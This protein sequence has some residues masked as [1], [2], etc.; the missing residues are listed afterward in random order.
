M[1]DAI[2]EHGSAEDGTDENG[3]LVITIK[4]DGEHTVDSDLLDRVLQ[5]TMMELEVDTAW[6]VGPPTTISPSQAPE[7]SPAPEDAPA[8]EPA[9]P[10]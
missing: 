5:F 2:R 6:R 3:N 10:V 9:P 7:N 1:S 4:V 8:I